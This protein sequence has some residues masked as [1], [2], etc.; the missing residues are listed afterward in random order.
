MGKKL[1]IVVMVLVTM[2][3]LPASTFASK[4]LPENPNTLK[5][6][7][8]SATISALPLLSERPVVWVH[9][10]WQV[11]FITDIAKNLMDRLG[12]TIDVATGQKGPGV[13][14][15]EY[16]NLY[17]QLAQLPYLQTSKDNLL[18]W[19]SALKYNQAVANVLHTS[20]DMY[21][22]CSDFLKGQATD[23]AFPF[24][25]W[26]LS[27][28]GIFDSVL[29]LLDVLAWLKQAP[30]DGCPMHMMGPMHQMCPMGPQGQMDYK[31][32]MEC[33]CPMSP[34]EPKG[35]MQQKGKGQIG[36]TGQGQQY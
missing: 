28:Q 13:D 14:S 5:I 30:Y 6:K 9:S 24:I 31:C 27:R 7:P 11:K 3:A 21:L 4:P 2:I 16:V 26:G 36:Q 10:T 19:R 32:H 17:T 20:K 29:W 25:Q 1:L 23:N 18:V 22:H 8:I 15:Q 33:Q 34:M 35:P 12:G